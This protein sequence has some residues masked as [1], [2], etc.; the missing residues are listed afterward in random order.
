MF[1]LKKKEAFRYKIHITSA[2]V[3]H[4]RSNDPG[5]LAENFSIS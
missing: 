5:F 1:A 2:K 3:R 4:Q